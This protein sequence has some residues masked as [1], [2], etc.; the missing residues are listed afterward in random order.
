MQSSLLL[1][2]WCFYVCCWTHD[3]IVESWVWDCGIVGGVC[4]EMVGCV[5]LI[6]LT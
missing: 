4:V 5:F 3:V 6:S 2:M 1:L